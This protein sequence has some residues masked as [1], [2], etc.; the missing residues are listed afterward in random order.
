MPLEIKELT[1]R[2]HVN[3]QQPAQDSAGKGNMGDS[4]KELV[5]EAVEEVMRIIENKKE[6]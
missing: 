3:E 1:I 6:R 5:K 2:V 4:S